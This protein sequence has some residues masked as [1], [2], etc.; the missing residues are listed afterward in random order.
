M[1]PGVSLGGFPPPQAEVQAAEGAVAPRPQGAQI[2][3]EKAVA[4]A[5]P[6][7]V[8]PLLDSIALREYPQ[9]IA[10][11]LLVAGLAIT[12]DLVLAGLTKIVA[13]PGL[14]GVNAGPI[15]G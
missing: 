15:S 11:A 7:P 6:A 3:A 9:A 10:G 13:S 1:S 4:A 12:L 8:Q 2:D 5:T 14:S